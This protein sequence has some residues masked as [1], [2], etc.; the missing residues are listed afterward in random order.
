MFR[1]SY[2][3]RDEMN[4]FF[5]DTLLFRKLKLG[6]PNMLIQIKFEAQKNQTQNEEM[7]FFVFS[8]R[9][10]FG[11]KCFSSIY[12]FPIILSYINILCWKY[13]LNTFQTVPILGVF[14]TIKKFTFIGGTLNFFFF[15][16]SAKN[17]FFVKI[18]LRVPYL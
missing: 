14:W 13:F 15:W 2:R 6:L 17:I 4:N 12:R 11:T 10:R 3:V 5:M 7:V 18:L 1:H 9:H 8:R 16:K